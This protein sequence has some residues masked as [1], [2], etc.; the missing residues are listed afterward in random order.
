M[1]NNNQQK[2]IINKESATL[3]DQLDRSNRLKISCPVS[4]HIGYEHLLAGISGGVTSTMI[5]HPLDTL[6]T[7]LAGSFSNTELSIFGIH[8]QIE[9]A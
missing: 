3:Q 1:T 6:K 5:L 4:Y 7:R 9:I 8:K 2:S